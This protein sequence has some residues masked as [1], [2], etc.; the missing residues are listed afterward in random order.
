MFDSGTTPPTLET[1]D[2]RWWL[3]P[4][5]VLAGAV[6][7]VLWQ[8]FLGDQSLFYR[9]LY[10]QHLGTARMLASGQLPFG[11]LWDPLLN[12]GQPLLANP[13]RFLLYPSRLLYLIMGPTGALNSEIALTLPV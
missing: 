6:S 8:V 4:L 11:L 1:V 2:K 5:A 3:I 10:R 12:G 7:L 13:N 9:D